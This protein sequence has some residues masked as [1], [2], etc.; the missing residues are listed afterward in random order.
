MPRPA[1]ISEMIARLKNIRRLTPMR[2]GIGC[3]PRREPGVG[4]DR[5][6]TG[7]RAGGDALGLCDGGAAHGR[8][9][10]DE[11]GFAGRGVAA[12]GLVAELAGAAHVGAAGER[13]ERDRAE[14][15]DDGDA[16]HD[17]GGGVHG[18]L[19]PSVSSLTGRRTSRR[20]MGA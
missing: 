1:A 18:V 17:G 8:A 3:D 15:D 4:G 7:A 19:L 16:D 6:Q 10:A 9:R 14:H 11:L 5:C 20:A 2:F 12:D 13:G